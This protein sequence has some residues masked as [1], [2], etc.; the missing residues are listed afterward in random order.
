MFY[1]YIFLVAFVLSA[2]LTV[3]VGKIAFYFRVVDEPGQVG[4]LSRKIHIQ[5]TPLLGGLAIFFSYF[6]ILFLLSDHFFSGTLHWSHLIGFSVGA[7]IIAGGGILDDKYNLKSQQ[8]II[9]PVLAIGA[10]IW[11]GVSIE[12]ITNPFGG[13]LNL[14]SLFF[15]SPFFIFL[16]MMGMMYTTKLLDGVDGLVSGL[17]AIG[18]FIIFLFTLTTRYYQPDIALAA[19]LL[20]GVSV[21]FLVFNWHPAK[22]FLGEGGSLLIGYILGVLAIIS[23]AKIAM[24]LLVMGIPIMDVA[25]TII[26]RLALGQNPFK[27]AD[28]S[29]LHHRLL[30][31]G[32]SQPLTVGI[33]YILSLSFGLSGLW[34]QSRGK[35]L[36]LLALG[37]LM[38][39]LVVSFW[40]LDHYKKKHV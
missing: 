33:F 26:R 34:L 37:A 32:L 5:T 40:G 20:T 13:V 30:S 1:F 29:H 18:G 39:F 4:S 14:H 31:L 12:K 38:F 16:W 19:I 21:G 10:L 11:G 2:L 7:L 25:W 8:Q 23:G 27:T 35:F 15:I 22:I 6:I 36:A 28:R 17:G 9:F 3:A 24:A